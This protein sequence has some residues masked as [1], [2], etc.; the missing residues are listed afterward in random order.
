MHRASKVSDGVF[1]YSERAFGGMCA[2]ML[3]CL[4]QVIGRFEQ[5]P[6]FATEGVVTYVESTANGGNFMILPNMASL[7]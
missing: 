2:N 5:K 4:Y 7:D 3:F 1:T 6:P